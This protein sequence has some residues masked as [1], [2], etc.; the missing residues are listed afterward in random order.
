MAETTRQTLA[1]PRGSDDG[2]AVTTGRAGNPFG[3]A[4]EIAGQ[5]TGLAAAEQQRMIAEIQARIV[6][7]RS[8]PRD[9]VRA[10]DRILDDCTRV[11]LAEGALYSYSRGGT[12][13]SGPSIKLIETVARRWGNIASGIKEISRRNGYSE[14]V[15]YA[16]DLESGYYDERQY[17]IRHWRD[18]KKGGYVLTDER[19]IYELTANFGQRRK[20]ACLQTVIP[21]DVVEAAVEQCERTLV[22]KA[23]TSPEAVK[24]MEDA[25]AAIGVTKALIEER[26]QRRIG[27]IRPAQV[28]QLR[29]IYNS[30][31][32][33]MSEVEDWFGIVTIDQEA[34]GGSA[35]GAGQP[36]RPTAAEG[37]IATS[38]ASAPSAGR[39]DTGEQPAAGPP[40]QQPA[41]AQPPRQ[42]RR[43]EL[44]GE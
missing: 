20:R 24:K 4:S 22:D 5:N 19:D 14:C 11:S 42:P 3:Q 32:D 15:S 35:D 21:G 9:P 30:L 27:S 1:P 37:P 31:R 28:V 38:A 23:D 25:F 13:I 6:V 41:A 26:I 7:A 33:G 40:Q 18:T 8:N 2:G 17:Q 36:P 12:D 10:M 29:K 43:S 34:G 16:W 44:F 39:S